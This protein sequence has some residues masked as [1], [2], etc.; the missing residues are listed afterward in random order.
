LPG[1]KRVRERLE[2]IAK[3]KKLQET[4][5]EARGSIEKRYANLGRDLF[6]QFFEKGA[7][8]DGASKV[9]KKN[10][11]GGLPPVV[12]GTFPDFA[13]GAPLQFSRLPEYMEYVK[14]LFASL[15]ALSEGSQQ[16]NSAHQHIEKFIEKATQVQPVDGLPKEAVAWYELTRAWSASP[17]SNPP[18][19]TSD[20]KAKQTN[21]DAEQ[22]KGKYFDDFFLVWNERFSEMAVKKLIDDLNLIQS[23]R[24][25]P[26]PEQLDS[27][28]KTLE[29]TKSRLENAD[30]TDDG[31]YTLELMLETPNPASPEPFRQIIP[32]IR[33]TR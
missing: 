12:L 23:T 16:Y 6:P 27:T 8:N 33:G 11:A 14:S 18:A 21:R 29:E 28:L 20:G 25:L 7:P 3:S 26:S 1:I 30:L 15:E 17:G 31:E 22:I 2:G 9:D 4:V 10:P 5:V 19:S 24:A 32:L 13:K